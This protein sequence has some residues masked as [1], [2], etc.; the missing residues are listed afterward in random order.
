MRKNR[1]A[2]IVERSLLL[3]E[4]H[5]KDLCGQGMVSMSKVYICPSYVKAFSS[6]ARMEW[7]V[8]I[9]IMYSLSYINTVIM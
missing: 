6:Q 5:G 1:Q 3:P 9:P 7:Q 4:S 2:K 8:N